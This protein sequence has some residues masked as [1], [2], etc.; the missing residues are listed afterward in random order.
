MTPPVFE[1]LTPA[2]YCVHTLVH[3]LNI[4]II[5]VFTLRN[6]QTYFKMIYLPVT[7]QLEIILRPD[8][9]SVTFQTYSKQISSTRDRGRYCRT[10][11]YHF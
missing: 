7:F 6:V 8:M 11:A 9:S 5:K 4:K 3:I 1:V 10:H 2:T